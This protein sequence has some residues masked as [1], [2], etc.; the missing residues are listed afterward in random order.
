M[1]D[2]TFYTI[3]IDTIALST[4]NYTIADRANTNL[5]IVPAPVTCNGEPLYDNVLWRNSANQPVYG[6][7][8]YCNTDNFTVNLKPRKYLDPIVTVNFTPGQ[9]L[10]NNNY[11]T[12]HFAELRRATEYVQSQ[13]AEATGISLDLES[14]K[15]T[16]LDIQITIEFKESLAPLFDVLKEFKEVNRL[17][18]TYD[19]DQSL[20]WKNTQ[21][22]L[23][24]YNKTKKVGGDYTLAGGYK[25]A[26]RIEYRLMKNKSVMSSFGVSTIGQLTQT[27]INKVFLD[28]IKP[29]IERMK[30]KLHLTVKGNLQEIFN[31]YKEKNTDN[32]F[33]DYI[34]ALGASAML[35]RHGLNEIKEVAKK[36]TNSESTFK[37][38]IKKIEKVSTELRTT[39]KINSKSKL[40]ETLIANLFGD[41]GQRA[42][43]T[44]T[45]LCTD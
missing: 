33:S 40:F 29:V 19:I 21:K 16:R 42:S 27:K 23:N 2:N 44:G 22:E 36:V 1:N 17:K 6:K 41:K 32:K 12:V 45:F 26:L 14:A 8:A 35:K 31:L 4:E 43:V 34:Y 20:C 5:I 15:I 10:F 7:K 24:I 37:R 13:I 28:F 39:K 18:K 11:E 3:G 9:V 38:I 30:P 25:N